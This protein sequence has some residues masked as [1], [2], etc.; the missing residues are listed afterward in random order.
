MGVVRT[1]TS[2]DYPGVEATL[3]C[4]FFSVSPELEELL[5]TAS[6]MQPMKSLITWSTP[7]QQEATDAAS[8][9]ASLGIPYRTNKVSTSWTNSE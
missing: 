4:S 3:L 1:T 9:A 2:P 8:T 7:G 6:L 5:E